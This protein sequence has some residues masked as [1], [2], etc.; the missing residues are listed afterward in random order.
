METVF[1]AALLS[2]KLVATF[3]IDLICTVKCDTS[4]LPMTSFTIDTGRVQFGAYLSRLSQCSL[5]FYTICDL[6]KTH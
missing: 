2:S 3:N 5:V 4:Y 6:N 1:I